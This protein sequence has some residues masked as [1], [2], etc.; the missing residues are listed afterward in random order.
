MVSPE[1]GFTKVAVDGTHVKLSV[2]VSSAAGP[3]STQSRTAA[4]PLLLSRPAGGPSAT[5][6]TRLPVTRPF[7]PASSRRPSVRTRAKRKRPTLVWL[8]VLTSR[9]D[10]FGGAF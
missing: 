4:A 8:A 10:S 1:V 5:L 2:R 7:S 9:Y 6:A 3:R